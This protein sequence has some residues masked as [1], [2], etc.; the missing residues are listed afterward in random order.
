[1]WK[2]F[3]RL[4]VDNSYTIDIPSALEYDMLPDSREEIPTPG[5]TEHY[6]HLKD[7]PIPTCS[8]GP[9]DRILRIGYGWKER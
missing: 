6:E 5:I 9:A 4:S 3:T 7:L 1:M 2:C 8:Q